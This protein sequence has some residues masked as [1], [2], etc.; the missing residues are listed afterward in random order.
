M[1]KNLKVKTIKFRI[2]KRCICPSC[3]RKQPFKKEREYY[4]TVKDIDVNNPTLF[5]LRM[6]YAKCL[7][8]NCRVHSFL[9]PTPGFEKYKRVTKRLKEEAIVSLIQDNSTLLRTSERL[10]R[11][12]N[13]SASKSTIDRW[14]H[15]EVDKYSSQ[16]II[17]RMGFSG[18]LSISVG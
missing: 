4:K 16:E 1:E 2:P 5:K 18:I 6:V 15:E 10:D 14:K 17:A 12:L 13:T 9:L 7:N 11:S 3:G 8:P